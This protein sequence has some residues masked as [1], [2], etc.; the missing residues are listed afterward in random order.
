MSDAR[1]MFGRWVLF[2]LLLCGSLTMALPFVLSVAMSL[3]DPGVSTADPAAVIP[4]DASRP[5]FKFKLHWENHAEVWW[6]APLGHYYVVSVV[7]AVLVTTGRLITSCLAAYAFAR[8]EFPG[9]NV[10]FFLYMATLMVPT[11]VTR[12]EERR[13]GEECIYRWW[14]DD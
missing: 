4:R 2:L 12:S 11:E 5:E 3:Q 13:V 8:L 9:R 10:L 6:R 7:V 1:Y 14:A